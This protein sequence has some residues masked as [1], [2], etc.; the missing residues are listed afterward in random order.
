MGLPSAPAAVLIT[1]AR[2]GFQKTAKRSRGREACHR[3]VVRHGSAGTK[4]SARISRGR[5]ARRRPGFRGDGERRLYPSAEAI[6]ARS[7][8][9]GEES[10]GCPCE[11]PHALHRLDRSRRSGDRPVILD[12]DIVSR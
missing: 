9:V 3:Y 11:L 8:A 6:A 1:S 2:T 4:L 10:A 7:R 12:H 5:P